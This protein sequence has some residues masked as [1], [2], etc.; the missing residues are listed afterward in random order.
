MDRSRK[1]WINITLLVVTLIVNGLGA[2]GVINGMSQKDVSDKYTTLITPSGSTFSI[3]GLI[4]VLLLVSM[5]VMIIRKDNTYYQKAIDKITILFWISCLLNIAWIVL[6]SF[7][8][9][10][11]STLFIFGFLITLSIILIKLNK[12]NDG[13]HFLLP[14]TFGIYTG[15]LFIAT[16]LNVAVALVKIKWEGFGISPEIWAGVILIVAILLVFVVLQSNK[17]VVFPLPVAWAY[18]GVYQYLKAPEGFNGQHG[19]LQIISLTGMA[20]LIGIAAIRL[21]QNRFALI[22]KRETY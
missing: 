17:N 2:T 10:G 16:V 21:Y 14:L 15:W 5:V 20:V 7:L 4:Y 6:F 8:Q 1:A 22:P 13:R 3:W 18:F 19:I 12:I 9:I 11:L